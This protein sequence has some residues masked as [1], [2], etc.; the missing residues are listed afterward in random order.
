MSVTP[1]FG[2]LA[3]LSHDLEKLALTRTADGV[4]GRVVSDELVEH[5]AGE[6]EAAAI[7]LSYLLR[8]KSLGEVPPEPPVLDAAVDAMVTA[9]RRIVPVA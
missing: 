2:M 1:D 7:A 3:A 9:V 6:R 4:D 5:A 8:R